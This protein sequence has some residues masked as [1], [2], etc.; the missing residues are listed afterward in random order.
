MDGW[1]VLLDCS[2]VL[3][4]SP[5]SHFKYAV[6]GPPAHKLSRTEKR[7]TAQCAEQQAFQIKERQYAFAGVHCT[8]CND[9][10]FLSPRV[11]K[12]SENLFAI[13]C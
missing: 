10:F 8:L 11:S 1:T 12:Q 9:L 3:A 6:P 2:T 13:R 5:P 4:A 7:N